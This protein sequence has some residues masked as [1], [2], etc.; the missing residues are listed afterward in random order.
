MSADDGSLC[1]ADAIPVVSEE[2]LPPL[3]ERPQKSGEERD[4]THG[5]PPSASGGVGSNGEAFGQ[6]ERAVLVTSQAGQSLPRC[7][8]LAFRALARAELRW[9]S[10]WSCSYAVWWP[11]LHPPTAC[12]PSR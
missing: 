11:P 10:G 5:C 3:S 4:P 7:T 9:L 1:A 6:C 12:A 8:A 2:A